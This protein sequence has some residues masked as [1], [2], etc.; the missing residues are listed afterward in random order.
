[1]LSG[2]EVYLDTTEHAEDG[3]KIQQA[4]ELT[5]ASPADGVPSAPAVSTRGVSVW[6]L[7]FGAGSG[8]KPSEPRAISSIE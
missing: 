2:V 7:G 6:R 3:K 5:L 8:K 1:V 4:L